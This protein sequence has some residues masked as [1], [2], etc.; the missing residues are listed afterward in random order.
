[1]IFVVVSVVVPG[2]N[3]AE[4]NKYS[5]EYKGI[6][7]SGEHVALI[8]DSSGKIVETITASSDS[9]LKRT[10]EEVMRKYNQPS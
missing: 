3:M 9:L 6:K 5:V 10:V 4:E 7:H 2:G 1:L 8:R